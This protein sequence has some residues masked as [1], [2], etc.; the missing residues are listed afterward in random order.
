VKI[1]SA[2]LVV[3][4]DLAPPGALNLGVP[5]SPEFRGFE[6]DLL[7]ELS[8]RLGRPLRFHAAL[9]ASLLD[10]LRAGRV[11]LICTAVT[12]T[13]ERDRQF[14]FSRPYLRVVL[15]LISTSDRR[16]RS[17]DDVEGPLAVRI[18]TPAERHV[19]EHFG[20]EVR[21][22]HHN[23]E[24]YQAVACGTVAGAVDDL[25][26]GAYFANSS[27]GLAVATTLPDT[28]SEYGLVMRKGDED[29]RMTIDGTLADLCA[30]GTYRKLY[31]A[32]LR[33]FLGDNGLLAQLATDPKREPASLN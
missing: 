9:W 29:L 2:P 1:D 31:D 32:W 3:G 16:W 20:G 6:V 14:T 10:W 8:A 28:E 19:R 5:G 17:L 25:P 21:T 4:V 24:V 22:F 30:D 18:N 23:S 7:A 33:P 27:P 11:D 12:R 15:A 26:I 13:A